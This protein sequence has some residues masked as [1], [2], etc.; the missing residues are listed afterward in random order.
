MIDGCP[1]G[2]NY[3]S[4][5]QNMNTGLPKI[6]RRNPFNMYKWPEINFNVACFGQVKIR[7]F[8]RLRL[9][10]RNQNTLDFQNALL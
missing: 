6:F 9:W 10:L 8:S 4:V 3:G 1:A 7:R 2:K 5:I